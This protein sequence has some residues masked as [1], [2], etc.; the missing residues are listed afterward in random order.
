MF[1]LGAISTLIML[2]VMVR[3]VGK[4]VI[5]QHKKM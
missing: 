3:N 4:Q 1:G 5:K 2:G